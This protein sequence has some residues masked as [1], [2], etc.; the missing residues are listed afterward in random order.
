M[1]LLAG[2]SEHRRAGNSSDRVSHHAG[3]GRLSAEAW[4]WH[5]V[6]ERKAA[7]ATLAAA[8]DLDA[9]LRT[10]LRVRLARQARAAAARRQMDVDRVCALLLV[11]PWGTEQGATRRLQ[12][13][14]GHSPRRA[15]RAA[16]CACP[17][18]V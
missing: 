6:S 18:L 12:R 9:H 17:G 13:Q 15:W 2:T 16:S 4:A 3:S 14:A 10:R 5:A 8:A 7:F 11:G 1:V